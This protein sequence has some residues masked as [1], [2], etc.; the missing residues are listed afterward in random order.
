MEIDV[1][2]M[3]QNG[4]IFRENFGSL[5]QIPDGLFHT[6]LSKIDPAQRVDHIS[7]PR[8]QFKRP[9]DHLLCFFQMDPPI[10]IHIADEVERLGMI[11]F[12]P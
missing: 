2:E 6:I 3:F 11:R 9:P 10:R 7:V 5:L 8:F 12:E 4:R 1:S